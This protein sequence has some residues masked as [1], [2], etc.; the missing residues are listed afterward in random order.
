MPRS[1]AGLQGDGDT[2]ACFSAPG[3][4]WDVLGI[5]SLVLVKHL[6]MF[7]WKVLGLCGG[8]VWLCNAGL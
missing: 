1:S 7:W 8:E 2:T 5:N 3:V 6:V 4:N